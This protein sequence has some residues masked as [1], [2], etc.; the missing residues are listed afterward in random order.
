MSVLINHNAGFFSCCSVKLHYIIVF[1]N[2]Q[3]KYP[4]LVDSSESF[5]WYKNENSRDDITYN[6]FQHYDNVNEELNNSNINYNHEY[7]FV[8]YTNLDYTNIIP[9][10]KK[11]FSPSDD[12]LNKIKNMEEKYN[13]DYD[14]ICVLFYRGNDKNTETEIC[15]YNEYIKYSNKILEKNPNIRFL[16]QSDETEFIDFMKN[17]YPNNCFVFK[18]EIRHMNKCNSTVDIMMKHTNYEFSKLYLAITIIMS[19]CKYIICGSG[20]CSIWIMLYR[21]NADNICQNLNNNWIENIQ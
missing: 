15:N 21:G 4:E 12:I 8:N 13:L 17:K 5:E 14:N 11:Y 16:I 10:V 19:K 7:Q 2:S 18:D 6:Y 1:I 20:N 3:K 9:V